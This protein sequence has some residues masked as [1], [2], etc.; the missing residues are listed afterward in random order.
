M[1]EWRGVVVIVIL[2]GAAVG[3][4]RLKR[5]IRQMKVEK[6]KQKERLDALGPIPDT[7][8]DDKP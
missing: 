5:R 3:M 8:T 7:G 4:T 1:S 6:L 2:F